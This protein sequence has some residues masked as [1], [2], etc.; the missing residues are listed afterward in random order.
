MFKK[1]LILGVVSGILA[2]I[3]AVIYQKVYASTLGEDFIKIINPVK[4]MTV[5][6]ISCIIAA[7]GYWLMNMV[8]KGKTEIVFN[9]VFAIISFVSILAPIAYKLPLEQDTPEL[10]PGLTVP[11][12]FFPA[13]AW[14]TLKPLFAKNA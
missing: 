13:L 2:G 10:F 1:L 5:S 12:H 7:I 8:L 11:M 14:F 9:L 6:T 3:A 4:I